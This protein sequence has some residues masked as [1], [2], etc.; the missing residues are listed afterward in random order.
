M[1]YMEFPFVT[2]CTLRFRMYHCGSILHR[3]KL[4]YPSLR[5]PDRFWSLS[6]LLF[7]WYGGLF[8]AG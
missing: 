3:G 2:I 1:G 8:P 6:N 4:I 7:N 5:H